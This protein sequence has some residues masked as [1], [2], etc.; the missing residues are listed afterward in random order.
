MAAGKSRVWGLGALILSGLREAGW[1]RKSLSIWPEI[2]LQCA[3]ARIS[4]VLMDFFANPPCFVPSATHSMSRVLD[5]LCEPLAAAC[6]QV[7]LQAEIQV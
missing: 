4:L 5:K 6:R 3:P 2:V 1:H 7:H